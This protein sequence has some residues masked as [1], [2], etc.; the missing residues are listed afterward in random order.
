MKGD[1]RIKDLISGTPTVVTQIKPNELR[2]TLGVWIAANGNKKSR[3][4]S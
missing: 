3:L 2:E 4:K 1:V